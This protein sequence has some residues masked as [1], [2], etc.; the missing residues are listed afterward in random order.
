MDLV[1]PKRGRP[2][3]TTSEPPISAR[4]KAFWGITLEDDGDMGNEED[5][6]SREDSD[7]VA[8]TTQRVSFLFELVRV[9][10]LAH[11]DPR[12]DMGE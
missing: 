5:S 3:P 4:A 7:G 2:T 9:L 10:R 8:S 12:M 6:R 1:L 11:I